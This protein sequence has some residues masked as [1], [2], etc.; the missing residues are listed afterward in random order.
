M[1]LSFFQQGEEKEMWQKLSVTGVLEEKLINFIWKEETNEKPA[2]L[3]LMQ[4][5]DLICEKQ[6]TRNVSYGLTALP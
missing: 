3:G 6:S 4:K 1:W 2:L 5:F